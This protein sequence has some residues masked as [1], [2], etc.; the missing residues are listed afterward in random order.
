[1]GVAG[2]GAK[3]RARERRYRSVCKGRAGMSTIIS[4]LRQAPRGVFDADATLVMG[5]AFDAACKTLKDVGEPDL[6]RKII[7]TKIIDA[8]KNGERNQDALRDAALEA[9]RA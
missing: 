1:M 9:T 3:G 4:F 2:G 5:A 8:A 7:A 6:V